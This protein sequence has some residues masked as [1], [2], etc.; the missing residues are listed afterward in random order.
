MKLT[1]T[2]MYRL[3][4]AHE[5]RDLACYLLGGDPFLADEVT[6]RAFRSLVGRPMGSARKAGWL[7]CYQHL[8]AMIWD[9]V[10]LTAA[11]A[12]DDRGI[13]DLARHLWRKRCAERRAEKARAHLA[14][15]AA[16]PRD[17][18]S[19]VVPIRRGVGR[20]ATRV[21]RAHLDESR[22]TAHESDAQV[23]PAPTEATEPAASVPPE[24]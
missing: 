4:D 12:A 22:S 19:N 6:R 21:A 13:I 20:N 2:Q 11:D 24:S 1:F 5:A 15:Q 23:S 14:R 8:P 18:P 16:A 10:V 9:E 17:V 7:A 3:C